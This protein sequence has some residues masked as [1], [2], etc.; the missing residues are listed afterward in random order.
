MKSQP[1]KTKPVSIVL[2]P[3]PAA[4]ELCVG[5]MPRGPKRCIKCHQEFKREEAWRRVTS[6]DD[7]KHGTYSIGIHERCANK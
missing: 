5:P 6:P 2:A 7:P 4:T 3:K 1:I